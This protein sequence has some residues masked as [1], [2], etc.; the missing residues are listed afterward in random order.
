MKNI[1][2]FDNSRVDDLYPFSVNH[3]SWELRCGAFRV[4]E[5]MR[6]QYPKAN[7]LFHSRK[8]WLDSFLK[9][10]E[11]NNDTAFSDD[12]LFLSGNIIVGLGFDND[13]RELIKQYDSFTISVNDVIYGFY[14]KNVDNNIMSIFERNELI[15]L[16]SEVLSKLPKINVKS[17]KPINYLWESLFIN[18]ETINNDFELC[19]SYQRYFLSGHHGVFALEPSNILLGKNVK[20]APSVVL[21]ATGGKIIIGD[22]VKIMPQSTIIGPCF[23]GDNSVIKIGAKIY[24]DNS[25][26]E[27]CKIGGEIENSIIHA[28]TNKQHEGFLGHSYL[29]EWVNLGADTNNS[30]LKNTYSEIDIQ[31]P[32]K[33]VKTGKMFVGLM[34]GDHTKSGI[35]SMFT[36]GTV[37][38]VCGIIV[39]DWF[40]PNFIK[41]FSWGGKNNSPQYK[42]D[43]AIETAK[44]VMARRNRNLIDE[45]VELLRIEYNKV[46]SQS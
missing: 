31:L 16:G 45:E 28:F 43:K 33:I 3:C 8:L 13:L 30:D 9:R 29:G 44:I 14:L 27:W 22:N 26:G 2:L 18:G 1:V 38:G 35:N 4:F 24:Q 25:F 20:I 11:L 21:D 15:D 12:T 19:N 41:S 7:L 42:F 17:I 6:I 34:C 39:K 32:D 40:M 23:I 10:F 36:T 37:A 5:R 46:T